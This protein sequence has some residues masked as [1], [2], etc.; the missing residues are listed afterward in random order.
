[1]FQV[2]WLVGWLNI[3]GWLSMFPA[4]YFVEL[5]Q[6]QVKSLAFL[7]PSSVLPT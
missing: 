3:L 6:T 4:I 1:M 7:Q 2:G 5:A